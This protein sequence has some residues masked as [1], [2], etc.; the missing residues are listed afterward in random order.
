M[1]LTKRTREW[2][3]Q[4]YVSSEQSQDTEWHNYKHEEHIREKLGIAG[5][6]T[7]INKTGWHNP[8]HST[9]FSYASKLNTKATLSVQTEGYNTSGISDKNMEVKVL[10]LTPLC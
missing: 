3:W 9:E 10:I 6:S 2:K 4:K 8:Y 5:I 1:D 7:I